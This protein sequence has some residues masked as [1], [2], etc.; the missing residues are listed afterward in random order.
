MSTVPMIQKKI[1]WPYSRIVA[2]MSITPAAGNTRNGSIAATAHGIGCVIHQTI[3]QTKVASATRPWYDSA[4]GKAIT[5]AKAMG[6]DSSCSR[7]APVPGVRGV[8][9]GGHSLGEHG[10]GEC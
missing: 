7:N 8:A 3:A 6:P 10:N 4:I 1:G 2:A 9:G 5:S